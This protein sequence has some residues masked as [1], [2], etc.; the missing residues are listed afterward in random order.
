VSCFQTIHACK[1]VSII[2]CYNKKILSQKSALN[3]VVEW[4]A[5]LLYIGMIMG[6][7]LKPEGWYPLTA[8]S[9]FTFK[10]PSNEGSRIDL[11]PNYCPFIG[12]NT[13]LLLACLLE[14]VLEKYTL[15][16]HLYIM[17]LSNNPI[18]R[19]CVL[20]RKPQSTFCVGARPWLHSDI[21]IW[22]PPFWTRRILGN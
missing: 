11:W 16:R 10:S 6:L 3:F 8:Q 7:I 20:R 19:K 18:C 5:L 14:A 15:R 12:H 21:H 13:G 1:K 2:H 17:G 22:V 4:C 9:F